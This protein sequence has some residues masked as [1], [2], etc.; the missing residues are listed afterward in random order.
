MDDTNKENESSTYLGS[1]VYLIDHDIFLT[2]ATPYKP[3]LLHVFVKE[4]TRILLCIQESYR[5]KQCR[6]FSSLAVNYP[7]SLI[8]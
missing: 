3:V 4:Q 5:H 2:T 6:N 8:E 1:L 7:E